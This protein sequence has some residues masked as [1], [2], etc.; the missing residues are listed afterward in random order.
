MATALVTGIA[1]FTGLHLA[2]ELVQAGHGVVGIGTEPCPAWLPSSAHFRLDLRDAAG[3]ARAVRALRPD[4]VFH[5]AGASHV[6]NAPDA[7]YSINILATR[8]LL[9]ALAALE[10]TPAFVLLAS[11]ANLYGNAGGTLDENTPPQP[12]NDYAVSKLAMEYM[13]ALWR[14]KLPLTIVRPFNYT[15]VG[16]SPAFLVPKL[17]AHFR[18]RKPRIELGNMHVVREFNDVRDIARCYV[19]LAAA[20][21]EHALFNICSGVGHT[22][23]DLLAALT[24]LTG[25]TPDVRVNPALVREDEVHTLLGNPARLRQAIGFVP[26]RNVADTLRWMLEQ[27]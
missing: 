13:A 14:N 9:A 12:R 8:N 6:M 5:L 3:T 22:I 17:V 20:R 2:N 10:S 7:L 21:P 16:Q 11:S 19:A 25:H 27:E 23:A 1:G 18:E 15:G 4:L 24:R 26:E